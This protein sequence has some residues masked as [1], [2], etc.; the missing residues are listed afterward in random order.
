MKSKVKGTEYERKIVRDLKKRGYYVVRSAGSLGAFDLVV[1]NDGE[2]VALQVKVR[3]RKL[4]KAE[5]E[6]ERTKLK[7][8]P[9]PLLMDY[10][11]VVYE[12]GKEKWYRLD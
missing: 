9:K 12:G 7:A 8:I 1:W 3:K 10:G 11:L 2:V 4:S 5:L 6:R